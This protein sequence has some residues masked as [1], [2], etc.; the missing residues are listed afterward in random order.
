MQPK[1]ADIETL[2]ARRNWIAGIQDCQER[3]RR[4]IELEQLVKD[5]GYDANDPR[6]QA[7]LGH[8]KG[9]LVKQE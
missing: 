6:V 2:K 1:A 4:E 7:F 3:T 8:S 9:Q 5:L